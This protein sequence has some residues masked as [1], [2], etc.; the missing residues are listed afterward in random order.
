MG[1]EAMA[2][3]EVVL[4]HEVDSAIVRL[5]TR[6]R[7][8]KHL[9]YL[10]RIGVMLLSGSSTVLLGLNVNR[11]GYAEW[12]RN[13]ALA[14]GAL[15]TFL[16]GIAAFWDVDRYWLASKARLS[17]LRMLRHRY[18]FAISG[19]TGAL[20]NDDAQRYQ[21]QFLS[22]EEQEADYWEQAALDLT[23]HVGPNSGASS[24]VAS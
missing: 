19:A 22:I 15:T 10:F 7:K 11:S 21:Q 1:G 9:R 16:A 3:P 12:S 17:R 14:I 5:E 6:T 8:M 2:D 24:G 23:S 13:V 20:S 18:R 4:L